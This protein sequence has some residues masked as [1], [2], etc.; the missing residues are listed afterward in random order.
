[1]AKLLFSGALSQP[2]EILLPGNTHQFG[3]NKLTR[4]F[5]QIR[6]FPTLTELD[7]PGRVGVAGGVCP[8]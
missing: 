4:E 7:L 1:M 2:I 5:L 8:P 6:A 3:P